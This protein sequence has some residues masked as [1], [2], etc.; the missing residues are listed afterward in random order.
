MRYIFLFS[1]LIFSLLAFCQQ[2][3]NT[4]PDQRNIFEEKVR[5]YE[6]LK[7]AGNTL[8]FTGSVGAVLGAIMIMS[9][10]DNLEQNYPDFKNIPSNDPDY[11]KLRRGELILEVGASL[12]VS[13][14]VMRTLGNKIAWRYRQKLQM[15]FLINESFKG[16]ALSIN[17]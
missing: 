5:N 9:S 3:T 14:I 13:G 2:D 17:F 12:L 6:N 15:G 8:I 4:I 11:I 1:F 10:T 16:I 7:V